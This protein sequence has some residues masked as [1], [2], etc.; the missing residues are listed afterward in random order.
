MHTG[1]RKRPFSGQVFYLFFF[2]LFDLAFDLA[3]AMHIKFLHCY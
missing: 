3:F 2:A 1:K